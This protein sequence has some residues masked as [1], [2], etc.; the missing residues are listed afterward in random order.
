MERRTL[1]SQIANYNNLVGKISASY[2]TAQAKAASAV[3]V[4]LLNSYWEI[5]KHIVEFEQKGSYK[6][7]YG[8][9]LLENLSKDLSLLTGKVLA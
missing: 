8:K 9:K 2:I 3:N 1:D 5:G 6:A 4:S 7:E